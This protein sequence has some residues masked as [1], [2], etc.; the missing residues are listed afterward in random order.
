MIYFFSGKAAATFKSIWILS[1]K[2]DKKVIL[3]YGGQA[4]TFSVFTN[5][6]QYNAAFLKDQ[7]KEMK[8]DASNYNNKV[9]LSIAINSFQSYC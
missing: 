2:T 5:L 1:Q 7:T 4:L 6:S 3:Y 8:S 9:L